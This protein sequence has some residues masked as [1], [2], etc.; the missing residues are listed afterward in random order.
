MKNRLVFRILGALSSAL[1]IVSVFIPFVSVTGY[2]QSLWQS[3]TV[4]KTLYLPIMIIVFGAIGVLAFAINVKTEL[5]YASSGALL[6]YLITQTIPVINQKL[7]NTFGVG[8]YC[9]VV[10]TILTGVMAFICNLRVKKK[11]VE[12]D[13]VQETTLEQVSVI[14]QIDKLYNDQT[15]TSSLAEEEIIQPISF[16]SL[17]IEPIQ[18]LQPLQSLQPLESVQNTMEP[19]VQSIESNIGFQDDLSI[20]NSIESNV[21]MELSAPK[22]EVKQEENSSNLNEITSNF[23]VNLEDINKPTSSSNPVMA[24]FGVSELTN[25]S[26]L[27]PSN[28]VTA[29]FATPDEP[30]STSS[31]PVTAEFGESKP[32]N[33]PVLDSMNPVT[34]EF[35]ISG[36]PEMSIAQTQEVVPNVQSMNNDGPAPI[37][38][39]T[40]QFDAPQTMSILPQTEGNKVETQPIQPLANENTIQPLGTTAPSVDVMA[41]QPTNTSSNLDIF[42]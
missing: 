36:M 9:L 5:A 23:N 28:P 12:T 4:L 34:A 1:I 24:E 31:N 15:P 18:Q 41:D 11:N 35:G 39:V 14:D 27:A 26:V 22:I 3:N 8:Y 21:N 13:K 33:E 42:G 20:N 37:N 40:A 17:P 30:V 2:S 10:G 38:P 19:S 25:E 7:F 6:F 32:T 16:Q 29:E